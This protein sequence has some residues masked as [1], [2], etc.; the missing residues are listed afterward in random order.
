M[1]KPEVPNLAV[2][3]EAIKN[4]TRILSI[5][6]LFTCRDTKR[7]ILNRRAQSLPLQKKKV[8]DMYEETTGSLIKPKYTAQTVA[9]G[10]FMGI[11]QKTRIIL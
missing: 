10:T 4:S 6:N 2:I 3:S 7:A 1:E 11:T 5:N 9:A 8:K